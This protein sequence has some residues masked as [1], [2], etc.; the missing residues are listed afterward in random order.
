MQITLYI[1]SSA[2]ETLNKTITQ[3]GS[4]TAIRPT[5]AVDILSPNII[6][7][8]DPAFL[9]CNYCYIDTFQ[10]FYFCKV[11]VDTGGRLVLTCEVDVL[12]SYKGSIK[13]CP[14]SVIR[15]ETIGSNYVIDRQ[16]PVDP[17]RY[18]IEGKFFPLTPLTY[19]SMIPGRRYV[20]LVNGG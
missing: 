10:R 3:I 8:Y 20:L 17:A 12:M 6:L 14:I 19:N 5:A 11:T 16:L 7:S 13:K 18:F 2:P 1:N 15:S 9:Q 4:T